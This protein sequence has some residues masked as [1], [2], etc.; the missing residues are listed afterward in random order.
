MHVA[1]LSLR[2]FRSY[3]SVEL[4]L[5][6]GVTVFVGPN[7]QGKTNLLEAVGYLA[8][9][10]SHRVATDGPL[11]RAGAERAIV[12]AEVDREG[13]ITLT[14]IEINPGRANRARL[15]R[16]PVTRL[17]EVLGALRVV[18]FS[19]DD[20]ALVKGDPAE[21]RRFLDETLVARAPRQAAVRSDYER[22]LKQRNALLKSASGVGRKQGGDVGHTL[23]VWDAHLARTGA[24]L[25]AARLEL[26]GDLRP[27]VCDAYEAVA[28]TGVET[29]L[30]Y[31]PSLDTEEEPQP[32]R[33]A[34]ESALLKKLA[35][36]RSAELERGISLA[37]PHRDELAL[38]LGDLPARGYASHGESW[39]LAL[40][41]RLAAFE[42]LRADGIDPV[43]LLDDVF[44]ELDP[45]RRD[46]LAHLVGG[47]EQVLVTAANAG[48]VPESLTGVRMEVGDGAVR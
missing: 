13:R 9:L 39:S 24:E 31:V 4:A 23:D 46:R 44:A 12:R 6:S 26:L 20:L 32:D 10:G 27:L 38:A 42:L 41:L 37:G 8:T 16:S 14:E 22:V 40:A 47:A 7:G 34:L 36:N 29:T 15:N 33:A 28:R 17:R 18:L 3:E 48:D 21:R 25:L 5:R 35:S 43:L 2:D 11:V 30:R 45:L 1:S 19:P